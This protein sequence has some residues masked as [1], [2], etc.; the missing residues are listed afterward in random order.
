M[1]LLYTASFKEF[2]SLVCLWHDVK[3]EKH[4]L[5]SGVNLMSTFGDI[6]SSW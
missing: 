1:S 5:M 4:N 6:G 2:G 3:L